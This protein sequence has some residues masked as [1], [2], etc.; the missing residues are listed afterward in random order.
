M[1]DEA[2]R[3]TASA[4]LEPFRLDLERFSKYLIERYAEPFGFCSHDERGFAA[5][6][7]SRFDDAVEAQAV[8]GPAAVL[9]VVYPVGT[10]SLIL[11]LRDRDNPSVGGGPA[12]QLA[13]LSFEANEVACFG[14]ERYSECCAGVEALLAIATSLLPSFAALRRIEDPAA[15]E[16]GS[17]DGAASLPRPQGAGR[18]G[19]PKVGWA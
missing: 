2:T 11:A 9:P 13:T 1:A 17:R 8:G 15:A 7:M 18:A 5:A 14:D 6:V 19:R 4:T 3:S 16:G 12:C 10:D